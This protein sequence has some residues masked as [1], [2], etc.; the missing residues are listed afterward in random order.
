MYSQVI[1]LSFS[2]GAMVLMGTFLI[3][4]QHEQ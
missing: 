2:L 4:V 1:E 3:L